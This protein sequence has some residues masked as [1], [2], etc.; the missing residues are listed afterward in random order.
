MSCPRL[1][2]VLAALA[3][4]P[5][6][7]RDTA[8]GPDQLCRVVDV[9]FTPSDDLQIV[10]WLED[11]AG[12]FVDTLYITEATGRRGLGNRPGRYDFNSGWGWP[13]GRRIGTFPVWAHRHGLSWPQLVFQ[14]NEDSNLSHSPTDSSVEGYYCR[15]LRQTEASWDA[16]TCASVAYTD[17][18][19]ASAIETSLYP[20]REDLTYDD[21]ID[22]PIVEQFDDLNPFDAVTAATPVGGT[23]IKL[24]WRLPDEVPLGD[25]VMFVEVSK[26]FDHNTTYNPTSYPS[27]TGI[28][29][30]D[31][32]IAYRGQPS[33]VYRVPI[34]IGNDL[35]VEVVTSYE[36]YG[37]PDGFDGLLREPDG[38]IDDTVP[39]SGA[40]RLM[41]TVDAG[42]A[43][44]Y[45]VRVRARAE[46][47]DAAPAAPGA[48]E[49]VDFRADLVDPTAFVGVLSFVEPGDDS[50]DGTVEGY[51]VRI[52]AGLP[53]TEADF[54]SATA[55]AAAIV[56]D[57]AGVTRLLELTGLTAETDYYV[58]IRAFDD[59]SNHGPITVMAF[60]TPDPPIPPAVDA[61][62]VATAAYGSI[63][64]ADVQM[65]RHARDG[66]LRSNVLGELAVEA[67]YT[68][69][70]ALAGLIGPSEDLRGVARAVLGPVVDWVR[71]LP[72]V[73][74]APDA[75]DA[76]AAAPPPAR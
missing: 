59:C 58:A 32:G 36:G 64:A 42:G 7:P 53:I 15:P 48:G 21:G 27:P 16:Q 5:L 71:E 63:M 70:P 56:P 66:L 8:A 26:E 4:L 65:L 14:N 68:F 51:E 40:Q 75:V 73:P 30:G 33:V 19:T 18:G 69:G 57:E 1:A 61:C 17:K 11:V 23:P 45:R 41:T 29:Y 9:A 76:T 24:N 39:G 2:V 50:L 20:P 72:F 12:N 31:Y 6:A 28:L 3:V 34:T 44:S 10:V 13:Y 37:D 49:V 74:A 25:Y 43:G 62:F 55:V 35:D 60:T 54:L 67:Y 46:R 38:T 22:D 52:R 47:D